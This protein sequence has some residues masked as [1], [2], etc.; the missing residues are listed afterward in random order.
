MGCLSLGI[1]YIGVDPYLGVLFYLLSI[2]VWLYYAK[3]FVKHLQ[4]VNSSLG[5]LFIHKTYQKRFFFALSTLL[6]ATIT[7]FF[8]R[9]AFQ[10]AL[11]KS[12]APRVLQALNFVI[13]QIALILM[14]SREQVLR[15][16]PRSTPLWE[17]VY[18]YADKYYYFLLGLLTFIIIMSNPYIG[19]G[20]VFFYA[21]SRLLLILLLIPLV[22]ALHGR[23]KKWLGSFFFY[24]DEEGT[25]ERF[26]HGKTTYGLFVIT[27]FLFF[28][29]LAIIIAMNIWGYSVGFEAIS[30]VLHK[31]IY[32]Y[33]PTET[34]REVEINAL[35]LAR[36]G[37][38]VFGGI[39]LA[40]FFTTFVLRRMFD[41]LLVNI[42]V[43]NAILALTRYMILLAAIIIGL[44]SIGLSYALIYVFAVLG[45]LGFAGKEVIT[46]LIGYFIIL[47]QRPLKIGDLVRFDSELSGVVRHVTM[48]TIVIEKK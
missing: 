29:A 35:R 15:L 27:S 26:K 45:S 19:Y 42:G 11:P 25:K 8:L 48:R 47:I 22:M 46:D 30:S 5:N 40:Y 37:L 44:Q 32:S 31:K 18:E 43:Q 3:N 23:A 2:V 13:L 39:A 12:D 33:K 16:I 17:W 36:V 6:Y 9:E 20:P 34:G 41:L 14:I 28:T 24:S 4:D 21:V 38:Y 1:R 7:L 10:L